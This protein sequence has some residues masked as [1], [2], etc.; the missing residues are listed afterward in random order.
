MRGV[1]CVVESADGAA[2]GFD[3]L[4]VSLLVAHHYEVSE[5]EFASDSGLDRFGGLLL[6]FGRWVL[7]FG[8]G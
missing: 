1:T 5:C 7:W 8:S 6:L 3:F 2:V 4:L